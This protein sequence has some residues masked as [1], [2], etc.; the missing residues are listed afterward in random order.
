MI[1]ATDAHV[2]KWSGCTSL[3]FVSGS[4][5]C[6]FQHMQCETDAL[7]R[8]RLQGKNVVVDRQ[9]FDVQQRRTWLEMAE[10]FEGVSVGGLVMGTTPEVSSSLM[11]EAERRS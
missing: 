1:S 10:E 8:T 5:L 9:N 6:V 3:K 11:L 4:A 2:N 7:D